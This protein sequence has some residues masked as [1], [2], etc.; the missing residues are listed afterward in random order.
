MRHVPPI[1]R[2][3]VVPWLHPIRVGQALA[4][5]GFPTGFLSEK[6]RTHN[7]IAAL[8]AVSMVLVVIRTLT[9]RIQIDLRQ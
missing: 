4:I 5:G 3:R 8:V 9:G 2:T 6:E 1:P 7:A